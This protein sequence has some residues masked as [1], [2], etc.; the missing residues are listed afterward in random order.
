MGHSADAMKC[1][2][3]GT[4]LLRGCEWAATGAVTL[5]EVPKDFPTAEAVSVRE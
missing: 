3:F 2:G 5:T 4:V 1:V